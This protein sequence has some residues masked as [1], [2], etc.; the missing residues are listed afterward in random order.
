[1]AAAAARGPAPVV[2]LRHS[3]PFFGVVSWVW[4]TDAP[5]AANVFFLLRLAFEFLPR[6]LPAG[7]APA[8]AIVLESD[9]VPSRDFYRYFRWTLA[10]VAASPTLATHVLTVNGFHEAST[11]DADPLAFT[12]DRYGFMVWGWAC[13]AAS[14]PRVRDGW[15]WFANWDI[16]LEHNVRRRVREGAVSLSPLLS[17]TRH[18][19]LHGINFNV[20]DADVDA[21][22]RWLQLPVSNVSA[23]YPA[24][25]E[26]RL[27]AHP[28]GPDRRAVP[29]VL[30]ATLLRYRDADAR[31]EARPRG[32]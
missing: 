25:A 19:G 17:R 26:L 20:N 13:P 24:A 32:Q 6:A 11:A 30:A 15:T 7:R 8:G 27:V 9:V 18:I 14:W 3:P 28:F 5:T 10:R 16:T 21:A 29:P 31:L 12:V 23:P 4:R 1:V 2:H 22:A